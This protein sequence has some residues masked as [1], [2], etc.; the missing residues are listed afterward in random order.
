MFYVDS[1]LKHKVFLISSTVHISL[2]CTR[3]LL[4]PPESSSSVLRLLLQYCLY[5]TTQPHDSSN[6]ETCYRQN[7]E[8]KSE[9]DDFDARVFSFTVR[10]IIMATCIQCLSG[11]LLIPT[12]SFQ[13]CSR[14]VCICLSLTRIFNATY[15]LALGCSV[16]FAGLLVGLNVAGLSPAICPGKSPAKNMLFLPDSSQVASAFSARPL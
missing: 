14:G 7:F 8:D 5:G 10:I 12:V 11:L 2:L 9:S 16:P 6:F 4:F 1:D 13:I 3:R 15:S